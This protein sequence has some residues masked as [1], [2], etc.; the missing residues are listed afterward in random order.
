MAAALVESGRT[1]S[2]NVEPFYD[3][4]LDSAADLE[5]IRRTRLED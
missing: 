2:I 5:E 1:V 4:D 3:Q